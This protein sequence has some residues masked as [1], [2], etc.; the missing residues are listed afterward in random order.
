MS[1]TCAQ[2]IFFRWKETHLSLG[3]MGVSHLANLRSSTCLYGNKCLPSCGLLPLKPLTKKHIKAGSSSEK[4]PVCQ[5]T[6]AESTRHS[7]YP[8]SS[9]TKRKTVAIVLGALLLL[10]P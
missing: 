7:A 4:S 5:R 1:T 8:R 6:G 3:G 10:L 2:I 9:T